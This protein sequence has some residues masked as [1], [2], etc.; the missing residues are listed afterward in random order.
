[1]SRSNSA[2]NWANFNVQSFSNE[3]LLLMRW[4]AYNKH[5]ADLMV[6]WMKALVYVWNDTT[7]HLVIFSFIMTKNVSR[8][9]FALQKCSR[10]SVDCAFTNH[11][12]P[13]LLVLSQRLLYHNSAFMSIWSLKILIGGS[14]EKAK[15]AW[16]EVAP[17]VTPASSSTEPVW[18]RAF[19]L[20]GIMLHAT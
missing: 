20:G 2:L 1:M 8:M 13:K 6:H 17:A 5:R 12:S 14:S 15:R 18:P 3:S 4:A 19:Y 16:W 10:T 7:V 11:Q 9:F